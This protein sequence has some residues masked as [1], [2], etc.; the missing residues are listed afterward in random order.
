MAPD[1]K[2]VVG[3]TER[4]GNDIRALAARSTWG[5]GSGLVGQASVPRE[6]AQQ[7]QLD[8]QGRQLGLDLLV[9]AWGR[10]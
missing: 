4:I 5:R 8:Q 7:P 10:Y 1:G 9:D 6:N 3:D 2:T